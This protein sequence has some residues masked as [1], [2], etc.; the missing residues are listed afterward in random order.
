MDEGR[1]ARR[2]GWRLMRAAVLPHKMLVWLGIGAGLI[3]TVAR[4]AI[5]ALMGLAIDEG[6]TP[7][8]YDTAMKI[9]AIILVVG[10]VQ[11]V[12]TGLRRYAA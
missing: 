8:E 6:I 9:T 4:V 11:A 10:A 7:G 1:E 3:W 12:C 5:P 2:H